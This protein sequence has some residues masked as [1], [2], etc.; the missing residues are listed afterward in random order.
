MARAYS[1]DLRCKF[2]EA[3]EAG[4]GSLRQLAAQ[5]RVSWGYAMKIR[6]QQLA[7][8]RKERPVQS[9]HGPVSRMNE[10]VQEN[11]RQWL[12]EQADLTERELQERLAGQGVE[13]A[14][15]RV[16]QVLRQLGL[17]RKKKHSTRPSAI[18]RPTASGVR[19]SWPALPPS[20]RSS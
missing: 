7:S 18:A 3:Y 16:G 13:V 2:L 17:R 11:L 12:R 15:S 6:M 5:F 10:A 20:R 4:A 19:S 1:D 8:G 14:K 9:R